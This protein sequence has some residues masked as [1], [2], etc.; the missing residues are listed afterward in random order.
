M[1]HETKYDIDI[2]IHY[3][4]HTFLVPCQHRLLNILIIFKFKNS[5]PKIQVKTSI[6][7]HLMANDTFIV[8]VRIGFDA[9]IHS[10][11]FR[12]W[13]GV[14]SPNISAFITIPGFFKAFPRCSKNS[15]DS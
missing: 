10:C 6:H 8:N 12:P 5:L 1:L 9:G 13:E 2:S 15:K 7:L 4:K 11:D 3:L 14:Q